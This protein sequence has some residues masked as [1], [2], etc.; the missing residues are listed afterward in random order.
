MLTASQDRHK[1]LMN[2]TLPKPLSATPTQPLE[3]NREEILESLVE[4]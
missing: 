2:D 4:I 3:T 1:L